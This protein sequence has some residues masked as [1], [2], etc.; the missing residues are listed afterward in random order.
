MDYICY[1]FAINSETRKKNV[2]NMTDSARV[3]WIR[4]RSIFMGKLPADISTKC[5]EF[6]GHSLP[7]GTRL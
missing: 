2:L 4:G 3:Y 1:K 6:S 7:R 5:D